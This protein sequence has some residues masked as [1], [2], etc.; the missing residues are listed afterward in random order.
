MRNGDTA[1]AASM[2]PPVGGQRTALL[3]VRD[4]R[5]GGANNDRVLWAA[6]CQT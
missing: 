1:S 2:H 3:A 4:R 6:K 5:G